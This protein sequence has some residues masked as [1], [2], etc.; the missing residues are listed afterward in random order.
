MGHFIVSL[1]C[2]A[3][4]ALH[5]KFRGR[6]RGHFILSF[7]GAGGWGEMGW[8]GV[9]WVRSISRRQSN[10]TKQLHQKFAVFK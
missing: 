9:G 3:D 4:G 10:V 1:G 5:Y 6:G 8:G 7:G 2:G